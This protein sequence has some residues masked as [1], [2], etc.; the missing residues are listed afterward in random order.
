FCFQQ[1]PDVSS[2]WGSFGV[3]FAWEKDGFASSGFPSVLSELLFLHPDLFIS[4]ASEIIFKKKET[5]P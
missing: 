4:T 3:A 2:V 5:I 1:I